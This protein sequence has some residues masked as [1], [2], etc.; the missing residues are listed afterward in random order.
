M[1]DPK[2]ERERECDSHTRFRI[3]CELAKHSTT[4]TVEDNKKNGR[5]TNTHTLSECQIERR[6]KEKLIVSLG[7]RFAC[8]WNEHG[9]GMHILTLTLTL[10]PT[11]IRNLFGKPKEWNKL[12]EISAVTFVGQQFGRPQLH[13]D[14]VLH[15]RQC[16]STH[17]AHCDCK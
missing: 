9:Y 5:H 4:K 14:L 17:F 11:M 13:R 6:R 2:M 3:H 1:V 16:M 12:C 15:H 10:T 8:N 7:T